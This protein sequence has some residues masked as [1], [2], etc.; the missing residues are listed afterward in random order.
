MVKKDETIE[1]LKCNLK[2]LNTSNSTLEG[3]VVSL[4]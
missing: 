1:E 3:Q 2:I 4:T